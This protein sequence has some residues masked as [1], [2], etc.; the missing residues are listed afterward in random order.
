MQPRHPLALAL[1]FALTVLPGSSARAQSGK[2][3]LATEPGAIEVE[4]VLPK[5]V[6]LTV[7]AESIIYYQGDMQRALG[8]M[9][10]GT[11]VQLVAI[12]DT[13]W[14]VRGRARHG[15]VAGW[16]HIGDL[17]S[18]DPRLP[19]K[20]KAYLERQKTVDE[21]IQKHQLAIGMTVDEVKSSLG[22][23]ARKSARVNAA[24]REESYEYSVYKNVP[25]TVTGRDQ[26]GNL[27]QNIIYVKM[28]TGRLTVSFRAGSV[29][30]IQ[31][32]QGS[33]PLA[34][35]NVK[36]VPGPVEVF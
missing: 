24:G 22:Q 11:A 30:E 26:F 32:T 17:K 7:A 6:R 35:G 13:A 20:L 8:S 2:S 33:T 15:D 5:P 29:A 1:A 3:R 18:P 4:G 16:M 23:P 10:P 34:G 27:V 9:A 21:L 14:K 19:E 36:I 31:E 12:T 25:Q 28:E